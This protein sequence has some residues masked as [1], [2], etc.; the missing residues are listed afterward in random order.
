MCVC[1][2]FFVCVCVCVCVCVFTFLRDTTLLFNLL[3]LFHPAQGLSPA[4]Y[5]SL[6]FYPPLSLSLS[7]SLCPSFYPS[8]SLYPPLSLSLSLSVPLFLYQ[9]SSDRKSTRLNS[10]HT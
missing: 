3:S 1:V 7:L 8:P 5:S 9:S 2:C 10:R 4:L 6:S